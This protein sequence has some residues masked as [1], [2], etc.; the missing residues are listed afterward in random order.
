MREVEPILVSPQ[1]AASMIGCGKTQF[2]KLINAGKIIAKK[3]GRSTLIPVASLQAYAASL[4]EKR[5]GR[6]DD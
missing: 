1:Q 4:P 6:L 2:Y 5:L 3:Q